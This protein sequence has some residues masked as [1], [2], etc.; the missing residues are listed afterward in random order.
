MNEEIKKTV[1]EI[2]KTF[3]N[4]MNNFIQQQKMLNQTSFDI[5]R[6][7]TSVSN[8]VANEKTVEGKDVFTSDVKRKSETVMRLNKDAKYKQLLDVY[9]SAEDALA[10]TKAI[11]EVCKFNMKAY[12]IITRSVI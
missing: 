4:C 10:E 9:G 3:E 1:L 6:K 7:E 5:K 8:E 11:I 2:T 12:D